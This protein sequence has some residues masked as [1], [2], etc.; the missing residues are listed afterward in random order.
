MAKKLKPTYGFKSRK[1]EREPSL[2]YLMFTLGG[3]QYKISLGVKVAPQYWVKGTNRI[4]ISS[5]QKQLQQREYKRIN[6]FLNALEEEINIM[7]DADVLADYEKKLTPDA[8]E[9]YGIVAVIKGKID[10]IRGIEKQEEEVKNITPVEYF[11]KCLDEMPKKV[12]RRTGKF[13]EDKTIGHHQIVL[14]RFKQYLKDKFLYD[15]SFTMFNKNF[16]KQMEE[17]MLS[18][19]EYTPNTVAATFSVMKIWLKQAEEEGLISDKSF[20]SWKSK[21]FDVQHIYLTEE[22]IRKIYELDFTELKRLHPNSAA[23]P[24][25]DLFVLASQIG[26]R[27]GDLERLNASNWD[28]ENRTVQVHTHKTGKT[29]MIPLTSIAV[30]IYNKYNGKLP[31]PQEKGK[32][33][34]QLRKIGE[35]A[36]ITQSVF[37]KSNQ[38]GKIEVVEKKKFELI[39]SHTARR[40]FATN[41]YKRC[42]NARMVMAFTGHTTEENFRKYICIEQEEMVDMAKEFFN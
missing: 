39:S 7:V 24:T 14:K 32:F 29:V 38:G 36:G 28:I 42:R 25:R 6:K 26:L 30:E 9:K 10:K 37:I 8:V 22:E 34:S 35:K 16:E 1:D 13:I 17:W 3:K 11:Q 40:S 23:E 4:E 27:F 12:I 19:K 5:E 2:L 21:G 18:E 15:G 41:L 20:H 31:K 33:N